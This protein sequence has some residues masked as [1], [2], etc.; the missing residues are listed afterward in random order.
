MR[1]DMLFMI[2][3][4][5]KGGDA[6]PVYQ[7]FRD[8]GRLAPEGLRYLA[9]WVTEDLRRCFQVMEC[10]DR[11]HLDQW[12]ASW[13]DLVDFEVIPVI[14]SNQAAAAIAPRL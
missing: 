7:R 5:F 9:S 3:E 4:H 2:I 8:Q 6:V 12:M 11:A 1:S 14:T 10:D 13:E